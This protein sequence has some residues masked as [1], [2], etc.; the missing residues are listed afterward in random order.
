MLLET[1]FTR[2]LLRSFFAC[3]AAL[4]PPTGRTPKSKH[5]NYGAVRHG[6]REALFAER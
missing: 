1:K 4:L 5:T 2:P 3:V 6:M